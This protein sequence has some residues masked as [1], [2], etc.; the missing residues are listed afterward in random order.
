[1]AYA[2]VS[3]PELCDTDY[4]KI[5]QYRKENDEWLY[6]VVEP[7][8]TFVFPVFDMAEKNFIAEV[9]DLSGNVDKIDFVFRCAIINKDSFS[10][11]Y[12]ALLAPDEGFSSIVKLHDKLYCR[13]LKPYHRMDI[14]FIPHLGVGTSKDKD[15]CKSMVDEWNEQSFSITGTVSRLSIVRYEGNS[16]E[17][18][19]EI[20][21]K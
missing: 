20:Q 17:R 16:V 14:D 15:K 12:H 18:I 7:H 19:R 10:D 6:T 3:Y 9:E 4:K 1:M 11:Y 13:S 8:I 21:L 5:Q 2:V